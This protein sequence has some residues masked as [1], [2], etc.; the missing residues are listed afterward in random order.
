MSAAVTA[1]A[2]PLKRT[3]L[4]PLH[5]ANKAKLVPYAGWQMPLQFA[6]VTKEHVHSRTAASLFDVSHM[7][8]V[9]FYGKDRERFMEWVTPADIQALKFSRGRLSLL[10]LESG[11]IKD[12]LVIFRH[13]D[14]LSVVLNAACAP[15]DLE[16]L[17]KMLGDF[18]GD[19]QMEVQSDKALIALQG[20]SAV[21]VLEKHLDNL[22][23]LGF[24]TTRSCSVSGI[25]LQVTRCGYTGEDGFEISV[26]NKDAM[27]LAELLAKDGQ[28]QCAGLGAR[29]TLRQESG[30]CLYGHELNANT[31][32]ISA[33]LMWTIT[34]RR[35]LERNFVGADVVMK[36]LEN[37]LELVPRVRV[38]IL[39]PPGPCARQDATIVKVDNDP[40]NDT[41]PIGIVSSGCP[42]PT[43][44]KNIAQGF[45]DRAYSQPGTLIDMMVRGKRITGEI[46]KMPFITAHYYRAPTVAA[47]T[48]TPAS[49][50]AAD[51]SPKE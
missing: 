6:G 43:V 48:P 13:E 38:G 1:A 21:R 31:D 15:T 4:Y 30:L 51:A 16:H 20:P 50:K 44:Q 32:P 49:E 22:D 40:K 12:D 36:R 19:V 46:T 41:Q 25:P 34:K 47:A 33:D 2:N 3:A 7:C 11:G 10:M 26:A 23:Q 5:V 42:S 14:H 28:V 45:V 24:M 39:S 9:S 18:A 27:Q 35:R 37:K 17:N 29:D 8:Q